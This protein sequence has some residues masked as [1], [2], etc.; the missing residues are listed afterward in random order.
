MPLISVITA[1]HWSTADYIEE[2]MESLRSQVLPPGWNLEWIVQED[3]ANP[4]LGDKL[5][6]WDAVSYAA[7]GRQLGIA[8]TRNL[9]LSRAAGVLTQTLDADDL[10]LPGALAALIPLFAAHPIQW[11]VGQAEDLMPDGTRKGF[12]TPLPFG[13]L[14][15]GKVNKW[16]ADDGGNWPIHCAG[17]LMRTEA[18]RALGGW[19][20]LPHDEDIGM[21][22]ALSELSDGYHSDE[23]TWL[24]RQHPGQ[25]TRRGQADL[26]EVCRRIALQRAQ[27]IRL[28]GLCLPPVTLGFSEEAE[29]SGEVTIGPAFKRQVDLPGLPSRQSSKN[30]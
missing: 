28:S 14:S 2:A 29:I 23:L 16:A 1:A 22:A 9:A 27:A 15:A 21:F 8:F 30:D 20:G 13:V 18:L 11:A 25:V 3:G 19:A 7:N 4:S 10:L 6:R 12:K 26:S 17:L 5:R 24:Y